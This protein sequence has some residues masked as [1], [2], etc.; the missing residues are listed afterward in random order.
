MKLM[1][2]GRVQSASDNPLAVLPPFE[3]CLRCCTVVKQDRYETDN[4][5]AIAMLRL[6]Q[7]NV[8]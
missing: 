2:C 4:A 8:N 7:E 1:D 5:N 3:L 6:P